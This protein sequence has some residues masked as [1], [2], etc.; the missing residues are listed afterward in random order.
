MEL[1]NQNCGWVIFLGYGLENGIRNLDRIPY[2]Y[3]GKIQ[4]DKK[5]AWIWTPYPG[6]IQTGSSFRLISIIDLRPMG[7]GSPVS[8]YDF[9]MVSQISKNQKPYNFSNFS[10]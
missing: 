2:L 10:S 4:D 3:P 8:S 5:D 1:G 9:W 6:K 7:L